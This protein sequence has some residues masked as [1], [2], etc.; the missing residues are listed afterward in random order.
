MDKIMLRTIITDNY[1]LMTKFEVLPRDLEFEPLANYVLVGLRRA[2]KSYLLYG[3]MQQLLAEGVKQDE[4]MYIDFEDERLENIK[5]AELNEFLEM[6]MEL[7]G[8]QPYIFLDEIHNVKG[9]EKFVRRLA[10]YGYRV[11]VTGSNSKMLSSEIQTVLGG[12]FL[13][14]EVYPYSFNEFLKAMGI[15]AEAP[16]SYSTEGRA[17]LRSAFNEYFVYG[18]FPQSLNYKVKRE[19]LS[20][21][22]D[23]IY[24]GD[25]AA[26]HNIDNIPALKTM[27]KKLAESV[28]QPIS[29][30]RIAH[31]ISSTGTKVGTQT[32]INY[33]E[34]ARDA[35]IIS[36]VKNFA[37]KLS[38]RESS[39]KYY[40]TD[41]GLLSLFVKDET[42][43]LENLTAIILMRRFG[44]EDNVFFYDDGEEVDFYI[45]E[46]ETAIQV[47]YDLYAS[48]NTIDRELPPLVRLA[49]KLECKRLIVI[50]RD[51]S[52]TLEYR[53][54]NIE[55]ISIFDAALSPA[56]L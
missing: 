50:T 48:P 43:L 4:I 1:K 33:L 11:Y 5:A 26:R 30:S 32:I 54:R 40:F 21:V 39:P 47:C 52:G 10:D 49:E 45:P 2:G 3:R 46:A 15:D 23:K 25:I 56:S 8:K 29:Y 22:Y 31:V 7:Y 19:Y 17:R 55:L 20:G 37:A 34:Y 53:G 9:W 38:D 14:A 18:G 35:W 12:R 16:E 13:Q 36:P 51:Q 41:N 42:S 24:L 27:F 6:F 28:K 44:R